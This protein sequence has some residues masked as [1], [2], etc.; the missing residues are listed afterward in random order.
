M[1]KKL[2]ERFKTNSALSTILVISVILFLVS[3]FEKNITTAILSLF[4]GDSCLSG[5]EQ[6][7]LK[8]RISELESK[9]NDTE[10]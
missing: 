3:L 2:K 10:H 8:L 6:T 5:I 9:I 1:L 7:K 4:L